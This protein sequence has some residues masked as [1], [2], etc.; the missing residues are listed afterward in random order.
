MIIIKASFKY[1]SGL[2]S[3]HIFHLEDKEKGLWIHNVPPPAE[4]SVRASEGKPSLPSLSHQPVHQRRGLESH[5][6]VHTTYDTD[7]MTLDE[8]LQIVKHTCSLTL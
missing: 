2:G 5:D 3:D 6:L 4:H 7:V 1:I 8:P